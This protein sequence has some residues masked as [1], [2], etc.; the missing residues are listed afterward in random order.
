MAAALANHLFEMRGMVA[1]VAT[2]CG[3]FATKDT[4]A[5][6]NAVAVLKQWCGIDISE[7]RAKMTVEKCLENAHIV[8]AMTMGHKNHLCE[9]YPDYADR[10]YSIS[11]TCPM[12]LDIEDPFGGDFEVYKNC[13][14]QIKQCIGSIKWEDYL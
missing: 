14:G 4:R 8:I 13:A 10:V 9:L 12:G 2:S 11:E 5:S 3:I 7:H 1:V 6:K